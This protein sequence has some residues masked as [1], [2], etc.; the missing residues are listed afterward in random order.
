VPA[1]YNRTAADQ[2]KELYDHSIRDPDRF[3][4]TQATEYISWEREFKTVH[5][6]SF[7]H[8]DNAWFVEG[9]LNA[10]YNCVDRWAKVK[11]DAP[12]LIFEPDDPNDTSARTITWKE[13]QR[14]VSRV[15]WVLKSFGVRK[16][17]AVGIYLPMV[18]EAY[19]AILA[20]TR[21]GAIHSAVFAGFSANAL[22]DRILDAKARVLIT[23]DEGFRGGKIVGLKALADEALDQCPEV[24]D[25]MVLRRTGNPVRKSPRDR[26][27][28]E[29][30]KKWPSVFPPEP[31][32]SEDP[33][34]LLYTSGST[35]KPK[36]LMHTTAG[37]LL[38]A[39]LSTKHIFDVQAGDV[40]FC[41]GDIGWIT[42]HTYG[43]YGPLMLGCTTLVYE[44][45][46]TYP[47]ASRYW[48][49]VARHGVTQFYSSPT[50]LRLLKRLGDEHVTLDV[51]S[52]GLRVLASVGEPLASNIWQWAHDVIGKGKVHV[53]DTF[54]QTE[55]GSHLVSPLAGVSP[56]KPGSCGLP[57]LGVEP[58]V[59]DPITGAEVPTPGVEGVLATKQPIP[60]MSRSVWGD[61]ARFLSTYYEPYPGYY[62]TGDGAVKDQDGYIWVKGRVDDVINVSA[63]RLSTA[64]I[65]AA[66]LEHPA[67]AEVAVVGVPDELTGQAVTAY[68]SKKYTVECQD[69]KGSARACI[70]RDIGK[71]AA[72]KH[73]IVVEDLPRTRSG[74]IMRRILRKIWC[75]EEDSLGDTS[76]LIN[77]QCV[78]D[79]IEAVRREKGLK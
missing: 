35:G 11:P 1:F 66:L 6:G 61:H 34:F 22:R 19:I 16:G 49:V 14:E 37:Y 63:H 9:R 75:G 73:I 64:E 36:G 7:V 18:P 54:F 13:L 3:W 17:D 39:A 44:G 68:I 12:A 72:P 24:R 28:H 40:F 47:T 52:S 10:S 42:G 56:I 25:C 51:A 27:W 58:V 2:Y 4:N 59:L 69:V 8:G 5:E 33:L 20:C 23:A 55:T 46:P 38:G 32:H 78:S 53:L 26:W 62:F 76:T 15:A 29:V 79:V 50:A 57:F 45:T 41:G 67:F 30:V 65:E 48:E 70:G 43:L 60:S 21:I 31:M 74:K 77:P 71:F